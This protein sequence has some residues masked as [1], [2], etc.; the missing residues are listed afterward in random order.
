MSYDTSETTRMVVSRALPRSALLLVVLTAGC[1]GFPRNEPGTGY[2]QITIS[3]PRIEGRDRLINDR[4]EQEQWISKQIEAFDKKGLTVN[5]LVDQRSLSAISVQAAVNLD[6]GIKLDNINRARQAEQARQDADDAVAMNTF[7]TQQRDQI[8]A[9]QKAGKITADEATDKLK[10]LGLDPTSG[11][12]SSTAATASSAPAGTPAK[13]EGSLIGG[14]KDGKYT[15]PDDLPRES[16]ASSSFLED[17]NELLSG[18]ETMMN[19]R[20]DLRM[21]DLHDLGGDTLYRLTLNAE[22]LPQDDASA[23]A[24]AKLKVSVPGVTDAGVEQ[25][26]RL[27]KARFEKQLDDRIWATDR[28]LLKRLNTPCW[29]QEDKAIRLVGRDWDDHEHERAFRRAMRC[30]TAGTP[31]DARQALEQILVKMSA[32]GINRPRQ[33]RHIPAS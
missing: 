20:N 33:D 7:R 12:K 1:G 17:F 15:P 21:D 10:K 2:G 6:P 24:V 27:A 32:I 22:V 14:L 25:V 13:P 11:T 31:S 28:A 3:S 9:D 30:A 8:L 19:F 16:T 26:L 4:R 18:R 23:W 5:G 29:E